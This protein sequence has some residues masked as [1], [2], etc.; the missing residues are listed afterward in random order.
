MGARVIVTIWFYLTGAAALAPFSYAASPLVISEFLASNS[1]GLRD[2]DGDRSDW[3]ELHNL[4]AGSVS[5]DGWYLTDSSK[6]LRRWRLPATNILADGYL[7]I[8]A[9]DKSRNVPGAPLH[10]NFRLG[11]DGEY[12]AL[13]MPDG[14]TIAT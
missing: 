4:S 8:Y 12:L 9:S 14:V 1:T 13:V 5:L 3:I 11:A 6:D 2:E 7:V 10:T